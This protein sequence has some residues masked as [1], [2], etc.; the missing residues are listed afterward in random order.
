MFINGV[1]SEVRLNANVIQRWGNRHVG[2]GFDQLIVV[3]RSSG[4]NADFRM[5]VFNCDGSEA[6]Q[7]GN[8]ARC[9]PLYARAEGLDQS[10]TLPIEIGDAIVTASI[11]RHLSSTSVESEVDIG[12]P[13]LDPQALPFYHDEEGPPYI[14]RPCDELPDVLAMTPVSLGNPHMVTIVEDADTAPV[15]RVGR[16]LQHEPS[17]PEGAN[18]GFL[19]VVTP[20]Q[21][22]LRVYERG[23]GETLSCGSGACA[24]MVAGRV[25]G[26]L[27]ERCTILQSGGALEVNW[28]GTGSRARIAG[29]SSI[30]FEGVVRA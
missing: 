9:F 16:A 17:L 1:E 18:V 11:V 26:L 23:V 8:G 14:F 3:E 20:L 4:D 24:A 15:D 10:N 21:A 19:Q 7:C 28:R 2:V 6:N 13:D 25:Q 22:R 27:E 30:S 12:I 5:R 29:T